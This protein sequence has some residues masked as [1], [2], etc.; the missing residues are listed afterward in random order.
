MPSVDSVAACLFLIAATSTQIAQ[1]GRTRVPSV[2]K[3]PEERS[4]VAGGDIFMDAVTY[5]GTDHMERTKTQK[6]VGNYT[7]PHGAFKCGS[8]LPT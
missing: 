1:M 8:Q 4:A 2:W 3:R 5:K 6:C 7:C